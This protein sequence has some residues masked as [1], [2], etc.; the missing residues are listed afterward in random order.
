MT[1]IRDIP[2]LEILP[3]DKLVLHEYHDTQRT[4]RLARAI[5]SS[6]TLR[7]PPIVVPL[8]DG[9]GR[10]MVVDGANRMTSIKSL[11]IPHIVAQVV[12]ADYPG[13]CLF[14]WNHVIWGISPEVLL[15]RL[16]DIPEL[17][18]NPTECDRAPSTLRDIH[19]IAVICFPKNKAY[20]L[21]T[22]RLLFAHHNELLNAVVRCYQEDAFLDRTQARDIESL[23]PFYPELSGLLIFPPF[24]VDQLLQVVESGNLMPPGSTRFTISPRVLHLNYPMRKLASDKSLQEKNDDL[25]RQLQERLSNKKVRYYEESTFLF[26]E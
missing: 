24:R 7:N 13:L 2:L 15:D 20:D 10:H 22:P 25:K 4:P 14:S 17:A 19:S 12:K 21:R 11:G 16:M 5:E 8:E 26:D 23:E 6:G 3:V 1:D 9:S 18:L